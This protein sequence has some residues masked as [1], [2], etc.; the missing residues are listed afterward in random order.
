[1]N[2]FK[3]ALLQNMG[4]QMNQKIMKTNGIPDSPFAIAQSSFGAQKR[5]KNEA[6]IK[7]NKNGL[8]R[9]DERRRQWGVGEM[10]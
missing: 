3:S 2:H 4:N 10:P 6:H 5:E 1:M 7:P 9:K 8:G